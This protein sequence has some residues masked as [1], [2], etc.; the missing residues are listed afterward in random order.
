MILLPFTRPYIQTSE[1]AVMKQHASN[2]TKI[3]RAAIQTIACPSVQG[4]ALLPVFGRKCQRERNRQKLCGAKAHNV[5]YV[6]KFG[7]FNNRYFSQ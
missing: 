5:T 7:A 1:A 6:T 2:I 4:S 3:T